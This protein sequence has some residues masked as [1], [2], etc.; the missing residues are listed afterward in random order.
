MVI[1]AAPDGTLVKLK[2]VGRAW[3]RKLQ[4]FP[5][6][7]GQRWSRYFVFPLPSSNALTV[8]ENVKAEMDRL[9]KEFPP[10]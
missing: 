3:E 5:A 2:D 1:Q 10:E 7:S 8:A 9:T 4:L 6:L